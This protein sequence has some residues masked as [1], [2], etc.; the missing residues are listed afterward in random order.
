MKNKIIYG[1][2]ALVIVLGIIMFFV[3]GFNVGNIYG[4]NTKLDLYIEKGI[5]LDEVQTIVNE[6]FNGKEAIY[7][8]VEYFG[9]MVLITLPPVTDE[10][11]ENFI[12]KVNEKY[13]L[14]YTKDD[15]DII[16]MPSMSF[17]EIIK[18]YIIPV[19]ITIVLTI[20]YI[21]IRYRKLGVA[22]MAVKPIVAILV[23]ELII[24]SVYLITNLPID[25]SIVPATLLAFGI[26]LIYTTIDNNKLLERKMKEL[27]EQEENK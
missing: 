22:K 15:L 18:S 6:S 1:L 24:L 9:E 12:T 25:I 17:S 11:V 8:D 2:I 20:I 10:E 13:E 7:Q 21:V 16:T 14:E 27:A 23:A 5:N 19:L 3:H 26:A 4:A